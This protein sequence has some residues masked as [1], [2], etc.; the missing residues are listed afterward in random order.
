[1]VEDNQ[2]NAFVGSP[3]WS[4]LISA[5]EKKV[6]SGDENLD[7]HY[8]LSLKDCVNVV[9][10][11]NFTD[12]LIDVLLSYPPSSTINKS[13]D[14]ELIEILARH[15]FQRKGWYFVRSKLETCLYCLS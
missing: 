5:K 4:L 2:L 12:P 7:L 6:I 14:L 13:E 8:K 9:L 3:V 10:K 11:E 15:S 1:L